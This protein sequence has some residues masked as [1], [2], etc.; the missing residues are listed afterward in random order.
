MSVCLRKAP[1]A[2]MLAAALVVAGCASASNASVQTRDRSAS[3]DDKVAAASAD[4]DGKRD[5]MAQDRSWARDSL[6]ADSMLEANA[7]LSVHGVTFDVKLADTDAARTLANRLAQGPVTV[8]LHPYGG[9]EMV[10]PLPWSLPT[11]DAQVTTTAGDIMLYQ[12]D[13]IT[14]FLDTNSWS[15]TPL[16]RIQGASVQDLK[17]AFGDGPATVT[18]S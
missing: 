18:L 8:D 4:V 7:V 11:D 6:A 9:F 12:G 13:Q 16:G 10:G 1:V 15:Y 2:V 5:S 3:S 17:N 14:I